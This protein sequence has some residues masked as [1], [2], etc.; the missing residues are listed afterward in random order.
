MPDSNAMM[1]PHTVTGPMAWLRREFDRVADDLGRPAL[2]FFGTGTIFSAP[3]T[4]MVEQD[5]AYHISAELP[6]LSEKDVNVTVTDHSLVISGEKRQENTRQEDGLMLRER[7]YGSFERHVVLPIDAKADGIEAR[8][9]K[10]VLTVIVPK[11]DGTPARGRRIEIH[12][13]S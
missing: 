2:D 8:F 4:D 5:H 6:G 7:R 1:T 9:D 10:G 12:A 13:G 11:G 3:L